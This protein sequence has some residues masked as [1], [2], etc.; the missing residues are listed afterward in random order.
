MLNIINI[1]KCTSIFILTDI[2][3]KNDH[4]EGRYYLNHF[5]SNMIIVYFTFLCTIYSYTNKI[6]SIESV[7][8]AREL[9]FAIH[10]YHIIWYFNTLRKIDWLHHIL[11][12][13]ILLPI[14]YM[15]SD[16]NNSI[17]HTL[18]FTT[19]LP[20]G[21][22]YLLLFFVRNNIMDKMKEKRINCFINQW[23]RCPGC[24]LSCS[25]IYSTKYDI[26]EYNSLIALFASII[27]IFWNGV[28]FM[29][30]VVKDYYEQK[31]KI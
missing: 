11:M 15:T 5:I 3:M 13:G 29:N 19:G 31:H 1:L 8:I 26:Y 10:F 22:D 17:G 27:L 6:C 30:L 25:I 9:T 7:N 16:Y 2:F 12:V 14:T 18:F 23:I 4:F 21:I 24:I 20:G 28:Y